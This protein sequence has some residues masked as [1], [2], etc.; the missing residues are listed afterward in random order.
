MLCKC[1]NRIPPARWELGYRLCLPCGEVSAKTIAHKRKKQVG[2][3]YNKGGYQ[4]ITEM[5]LKTLGR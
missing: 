5:D 3:T 2:I 4:Y 1:G